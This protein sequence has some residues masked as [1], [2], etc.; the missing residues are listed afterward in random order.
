M[1]RSARFSGACAISPRPRVAPIIEDYWARDEFPFQVV[2]KMAELGIGGV[3][4]EGFGAAG[5]SW[6][7]NGFIAMELAR[8]DASVA[9][10]WG[11][12]R[13]PRPGRSTCAA[14]RSR[15]SAGCP[16]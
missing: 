3:G 9:T 16:A 4:Y 6:V 12:Y 8:I 2:P 11:A 5:G 14:T 15:S 1:T 10:F 13:P 7:L